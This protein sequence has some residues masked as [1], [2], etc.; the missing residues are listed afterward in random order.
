MQDKKLLAL[1][2]SLL[3]AVNYYNYLAIDQSEKRE[4]IRLLKAREARE[5]Q[6]G[7][8]LER[9]AQ[10]PHDDAELQGFWQLF[11]PASLSASLAQGEFATLLKSAVERSGMTIDKMDWGE[12]YAVGETF[13]THLPVHLSLFGRPES[14]RTFQNQLAESE[15]L[16]RITSLLIK[17]NKRNKYQLQYKMQIT[18][19]QMTE[20][21]DALQ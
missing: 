2:V 18:G 19:Y 9:M 5:R 1:L 20:A 21:V 3:I 14:F 16:F 8:A 17:R 15:K 7:P 11:Y 13:Y 12:P 6:M 10:G 4:K